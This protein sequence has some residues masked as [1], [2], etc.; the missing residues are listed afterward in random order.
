M[1]EHFIPFLFFVIAMTGTPGPGNLTMMAIGQASGF[2]SAMPFLLGAVISFA[3]LNTLV[4]FGLGEIITASPSIGLG[5]KIA[6]MAYILYLAAKVFRMRP[7]AG[8]D[9][10]AR[11]FSILEGLIIHPLSPKSWAMSVAGFSQFSDPTAPLTPQ[12]ALFVGLFF[13]GQ[14]SAHSLWCGAGASIL[15]LFRSPVL[16]GGFNGLMVTLMISATV[17]AMF[18]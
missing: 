2:R 7:T 3:A 1:F 12:V 14:A 10:P 18:A 9:A 11:R 4:G 5:M 17:Y 13:V 8:P 16:L 6:G 15:R